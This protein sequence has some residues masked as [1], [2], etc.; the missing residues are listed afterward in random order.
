MHESKLTNVN[1]RDPRLEYVCPMH[2]TAHS[3]QPLINIALSAVRECK[4]GM[5]QA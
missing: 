1:K 5:L 3:L 4:Q 2:K